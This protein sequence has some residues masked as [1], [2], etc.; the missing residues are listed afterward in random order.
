MP[1]QLFE[2]HRKRPRE[3]SQWSETPPPTSLAFLWGA[4]PSATSFFPFYTGKYLYFWKGNFN[5]L[6]VKT[7]LEVDDRLW[8][9]FSML[10]M[11]KK[12]FRRKNEVIEQLIRDYVESEAP[13]EMS[14]AMLS[15]D[16]ERAAFEGMKD[17]LLMNDTL[18]GKHVAVLHGKV[19]DSDANRNSLIERAYKKHGYVPIFFGFVGA[20]RT[21]EVPSPEVR[22]GS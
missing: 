18:R 5:R 11:R 22:R 6:M 2:R 7:T 3:R 9:K 13:Y 10:V 15:F 21:V 19:V 1:P 16:E 20:E 17:S 8:K 14:D 12:G 4:R